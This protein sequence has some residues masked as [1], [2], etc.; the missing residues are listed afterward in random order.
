SAWRQ[1][2]PA[3]AVGGFFQNGP[4][5]YRASHLQCSS[6]PFCKGSV[7]HGSRQIGYPLLALTISYEHWYPYLDRSS[8]S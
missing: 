6:P 4:P 2:Y 5:L 7:L 3:L 8:G 1:G